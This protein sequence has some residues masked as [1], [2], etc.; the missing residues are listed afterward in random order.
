MQEARMHQH[1]S[2]YTTELLQV[3]QSN[4]TARPR[5]SWASPV[6]NREMKRGLRH[7]TLPPW[8][9]TGTLEMRRSLQDTET[10]F[11]ANTRG[12]TQRDRRCPSRPF[13]CRGCRLLLHSWRRGAIPA[14][15]HRVT[16]GE[17][18][19]QVPART[20]LWKP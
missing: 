9:Y 12:D 10:T 2:P 18:R 19:A 13:I 17:N 14:S 6:T 15:I 1:I 4:Q 11:R 20:H 16:C 3:S 8:D 5:Y 7:Q